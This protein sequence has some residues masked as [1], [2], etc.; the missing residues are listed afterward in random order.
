[1]AFTL[2]ELIGAGNFADVGLATGGALHILVLPD[3]V[4]DAGAMAVMAYL[5]AQMYAAQVADP[6]VN[7]IERRVNLTTDN[8]LQQVFTITFEA[9]VDNID[10]TFAEHV[11]DPFT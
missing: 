6:T 1:M 2:T 4:Y 9:D 3:A 10:S 5:C 7:A 11:D 8:K